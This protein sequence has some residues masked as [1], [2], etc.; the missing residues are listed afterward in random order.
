MSRDRVKTYPCQRSPPWEQRRL[1]AGLGPCL[2][3]VSSWVCGGLK[4]VEVVA[5]EGEEETMT[6]NKGKGFLYQPS[7]FKTS[8]R[9]KQ[10]SCA[11]R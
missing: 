11:P 1:L 9:S 3:V 7:V 2:I 10:G 6:G 8:F 5:D 4:V